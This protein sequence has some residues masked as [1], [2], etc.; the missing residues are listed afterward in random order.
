MSI[1]FIA[2]L[3]AIAIVHGALA[4]IH[5]LPEHPPHNVNSHWATAYYYL[6][7]HVVYSVLQV[8]PV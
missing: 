3:V 8:C 7:Y 2:I 5:C 1:V 4:S 6:V